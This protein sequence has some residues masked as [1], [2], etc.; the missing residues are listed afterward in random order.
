MNN[1]SILF[2]NRP[3]NKFVEK[4]F[5]LP[6]VAELLNHK[7]KKSGCLLLDQADDNLFFMNKF[8]FIK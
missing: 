8:V 2:P 1:F 3:T 6:R 5:I 4:F 7:E